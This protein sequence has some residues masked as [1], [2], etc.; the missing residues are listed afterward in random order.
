M[1]AGLVELVGMVIM[2]AVDG[3][4]GEVWLAVDALVGR[5]DLGTRA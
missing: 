2:E 4:G 5:A 3:H 1:H